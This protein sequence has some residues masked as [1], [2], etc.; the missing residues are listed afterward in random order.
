L[1]WNETVNELEENTGEEKC[2]VL[3]MY[4]IEKHVHSVAKKTDFEGSG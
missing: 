3:R 4:D 2:M 1:G